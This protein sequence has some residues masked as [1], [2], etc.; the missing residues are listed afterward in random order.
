MS[1]SNPDEATPL[2]QL[3][4]TR[5]GEMRRQLSIVSGSSAQ[6]SLALAPLIA[7]EILHTL[8]HSLTH[9]HTRYSS[10]I[11]IFFIVILSVV[12]GVKECIVMIIMLPLYGVVTCLLTHSLAYSFA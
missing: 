12:Y 4:T 8:T 5:R 9:S 3:A 7:G 2:L 6:P 10:H 1:S 11:T